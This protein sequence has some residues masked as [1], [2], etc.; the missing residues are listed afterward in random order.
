MRMGMRARFVVGFLLA[1]GCSSDPD[2][3][4]G[5]SGACIGLTS[6]A[7]TTEVQTALIEIEPGG[8]IAFGAGTFEMTGELSLDVAGVTLVG[9]GMDATILSY[10]T[11]TNGAQ[12]I[13]VTA[14][15]FTARDFAIEDTKGDALK[16][17]GSTGV[18]I[19]KVRVEWTGGPKETNGAYG[20]YPVQC[21][22]VLIED[23]VAKAASDAGVYVGQ[24]DQIIVRRNRAELNVAGIEIE[25]STNAD[26]YDNVATTNT[27]GILVFNLPGLDVANGARTRVYDN[28]VFDNNTENFAPPGNIV[29]K[30]PMGSGI[31][32]LAAHEVEI[33]RNTIKDHEAINIGMVSYVPVGAVNDPK[34]DQYPTAIHIHDNTLSGVSDMPTGEIGG[35]LISAIGEIHPQG[36]FIAPDIV[37]D[38]VL[39]PART[40]GN[41]TEKICIHDNGDANFMNLAWPLS[42]GALPS[43]SLAPH[44]CTL[45][46]VPSVTL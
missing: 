10:K 21:K 23:S 7:S 4:E 37:W 24:S 8:T 41:P 9:K 13:L 3:C 20:L 27:G 46:A 32:I 16:I 40:P 5:I 26:V 1:T 22:K 44:A 28:Q 25:N 43:E 39:D 30:V 38:G 33:F 2:P 14:D 29:G 6:G 18:T 35:L 31:I 45:P 17:L 34:Y 36:P 15:N 19:Q 12:G 42:E 11:Q